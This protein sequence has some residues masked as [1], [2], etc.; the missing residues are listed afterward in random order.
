MSNDRIQLQYICGT[1]FTMMHR[2]SLQT[3]FINLYSVHCTLYAIWKI[4]EQFISC[5]TRFKPPPLYPSAEAQYK[6]TR[7]PCGS[8]S[9]SERFGGDTKHSPLPG[10]EPCGLP[11]HS[12]VRPQ[13]ARFVKE[14]QVQKVSNILRDSFVFIRAVWCRSR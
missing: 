13:T 12:L 8:Q 11:A 7:K 3:T 5:I 10:F 4:I 14:V 1:I 9:H 2:K 6:L